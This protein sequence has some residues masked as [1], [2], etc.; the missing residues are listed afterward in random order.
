[1]AFLDI[2]PKT[3]GHTIIIPKEHFEN[4][5]DID[6][7]VIEHIAYISKEISQDYKDTLNCTGLNIIQSNEKDGQQE[8]MHY[9]MHIVPRYSDDGLNV[10]HMNK[11]VGKIDVKSVWEEL[12]KG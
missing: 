10:W 1:M 8:I 2:Y 6:E 12:K 11:Q 7:N 4:I 5:Y 9:H 3:K